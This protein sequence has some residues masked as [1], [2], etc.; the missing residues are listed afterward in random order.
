MALK[1]TVTVKGIS[2]NNAYLRLGGI[3]GGKQTGDRMW[4]ADIQCF[5][6]GGTAAL[7]LDQAIAATASAQ[8]A[9]DNAVTNDGD[10]STAQV[11]LSKALTAQASAQAAADATR[12]DLGAVT[13]KAQWVSGQDSYALL[14]AAMKQMYP[15]LTNA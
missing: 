3:T 12:F 8:T 7:A 9:Y 10:V 4:F 6:D 2:I 14:Y 13:V 1:G 11:A 15:S 5:T